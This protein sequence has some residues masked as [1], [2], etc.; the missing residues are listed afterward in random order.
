MQ[1]L[2]VKEFQGRRGLFKTLGVSALLATWLA[3]AQSE[4]VKLMVGFP[5]GGGTGA[6]AIIHDGGLKAQ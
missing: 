3:H 2:Q 4:P 1:I 6:I 5:P